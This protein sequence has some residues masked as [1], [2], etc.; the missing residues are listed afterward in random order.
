MISRSLRT[1]LAIAGT[2]LA[3]AIAAP[4]SAAKF[5]ITVDDGGRCDGTWQTTGPANSPTVTCVPGTPPP[6]G[7]PTCTITPS[8]T[9]AANT[10]VPLTLTNCTAPGGGALTYS[11]N[12]GTIGGTQVATTQ[13][14]TTPLLAATTTYWATVTADGLSTSYSTT[15]TVGSVTP[16]ATGNC[17]K[18]S[19]VNLGDL[20][21]N[22]SRTVSANMKGAAVAYGKIT[23]PN[24]L[25]A[26]WLGRTTQ[27]SVFEYGDLAYWKKVYLSKSACDFTPSPSAFGQGT[28]VNI[29][30]TYGTVG[31]NT[32][33][34][35]PGDVW[36]VNVKNESM[37][38]SGSCG[39]GLSCNFA[40]TVH[41][42]SN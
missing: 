22:G 23:I 36:Y 39:L 12:Q 24:P 13:N 37:F 10:S 28:G 18:Y 14:F 41:P 19:A 9:V 31:Y 16:P 34:V 25:P 32:V 17:S 6:A 35:Q 1:T 11:W 21:I 27:I 20:Q 15:V 7:A 38:G 40:V 42:P 5:T 3:F 30:L 2:V 33:T 4:A 26:N 8:Q 29:Y